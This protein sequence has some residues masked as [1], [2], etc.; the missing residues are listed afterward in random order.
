MSTRIRWLGHAAIGLETGGHH[1]LIDPFFTNNP[2]A[3]ITA[4]QA[5]AGHGM[6]AHMTGTSL[7]TCA[8]AG[9]YL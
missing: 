1:V 5:R 4:E 3:A 8:G 7:S 9:Q 2:A 6:L